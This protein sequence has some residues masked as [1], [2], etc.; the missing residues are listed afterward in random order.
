MAIPVA[1][2]ATLGLAC[3][4][5][6]SLR[7]PQAAIT[8][9]RLAGLP[10]QVNVFIWLKGGARGYDEELSSAVRENVDDSFNYALKQRGG[11]AFASAGTSRLDHYAEFY[12]WTG[13]AMKEIL[14]ESTGDSP[15]AHRSVT[16]WRYTGDLAAW[17]PVLNADFVLVSFF[18]YSKRGRG[19]VAA[20]AAGLTGSGS[21]AIACVVALQNG[22]VVWCNYIPNNSVAMEERG[23]AQSAVDY[24][25][26][27]L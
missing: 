10:T 1:V 19:S 11:R 27:G 22:R 13:R 3:A 25:L 16:E 6:P 26:T 18:H 2:L 17:Q 24:L 21:R 14:A 8:P 9:A 23:P 20:D 12:R 5:G 15:G 4:H 7:D